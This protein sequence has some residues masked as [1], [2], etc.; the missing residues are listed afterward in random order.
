MD[1]V[2]V[3]RRIFQRIPCFL[4]GSFKSSQ[5]QLGHAIF[6]NFSASGIECKTYT[7]LQKGEQIDI[8][9]ATR[10]RMPLAARGTV[11]WSYRSDALTY[12]GL[13]FENPIMVPINEIM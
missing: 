13:V 3:D 7:P 12:A 1:T 2:S 8:T 6:E 4:Q 11:C 5:G 10:K 9:L